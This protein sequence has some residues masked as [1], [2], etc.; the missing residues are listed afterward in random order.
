MRTG[1]SRPTVAIKEASQG[2]ESRRE[3]EGKAVGNRASRLMRSIPLGLALLLALGLGG[4]AYALTTANSAAGGPAGAHRGAGSSMRAPASAA[5]SRVD[6]FR[7]ALQSDGFT[8]GAGT[9]GPVDFA[10]MPDIGYADSAAGN[11]FGQPYKGIYVHPVVGPFWLRPDQAIVYLGPTPPRADYFSFMPFLWLRHYS[12]PPIRDWLF[13][14]LG[15]PLNN[16]LI[17]TEGGGDP[18]QRQHDGDLHRRP[19]HL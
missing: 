15:D 7:A 14:S 11:E 18:V 19:R 12:T 16:A 2:S 17:K 4:S 3:R 5:D 1:G 9:T 6:A 10:A 13:A 8:V